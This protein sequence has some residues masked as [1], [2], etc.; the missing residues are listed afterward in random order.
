MIDFTRFNEWT[1]AHKK[2]SKCSLKYH[3]SHNSLHI[4]LY[5]PLRVHALFLSYG[6]CT[7]CI[8]T[9]CTLES[10]LASN[11]IMIYDRSANRAWTVKSITWL[12]RNRKSHYI[13]DILL[14]HLFK[15]TIQLDFRC[16]CFFVRFNILLMSVCS[17]IS[18]S[19]L[20]NVW[21]CM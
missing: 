10:R 18:G 14:L 20:W 17:D 19:K 2:N 4:N 11:A 21:L 8:L 12:S 15:N 16:F 7:H 5:S 3:P 1:F 9:V 6:T 13:F